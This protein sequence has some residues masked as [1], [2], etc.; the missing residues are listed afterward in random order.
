MIV[1]NKKVDIGLVVGNYLV[2]KKTKTNEITATFNEIDKYIK[3]LKKEVKE[4]SNI[5][6]EIN[7]DR[8][9][10]LYYKKYYFTYE[11]GVEINKNVEYADFRLRFVGA[12][13][14][15][16]LVSAYKA[17]ERTIRKNSELALAQT[18]HK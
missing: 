6:L 1:L 14:E 13:G 7:F 11:N 16:I 2:I 3:E 5:I 10:L 12:L 18:K 17:V 9:S 4:K 8:E 15:E